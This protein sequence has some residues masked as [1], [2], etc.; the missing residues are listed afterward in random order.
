MLSGRWTR[1][2]FGGGMVSVTD[3][4]VHPLTG[5]VLGTKD[6]KA[7][8]EIVQATEAIISKHYERAR[9]YRDANDVLKRVLAD[10][11]EYELPKPVNRTKTQERVSRCPRCGDAA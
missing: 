4:L 11:G 9:M 8:I 6:P 5:E 3:P 7:L 1:H 10:Q 2:G